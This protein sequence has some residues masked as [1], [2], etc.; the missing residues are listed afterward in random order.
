MAKHTL[1]KSGRVLLCADDTLIKDF[2][3]RDNGEMP[4]VV[5]ISKTFGLLNQE[6]RT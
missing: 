5:S 2:E 3:E 4:V 6:C 1:T